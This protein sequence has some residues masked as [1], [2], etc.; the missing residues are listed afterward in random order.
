MLQIKKVENPLLVVDSQTKMQKAE[1]PFSV[2]HFYEYENS[3]LSL[4]SGSRN[5]KSVILRKY[6]SGA[7]I[8]SG[9]LTFSG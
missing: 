7:Q 8:K 5:I 3:E 9:K 6:S 2:V 4:F 1:Y